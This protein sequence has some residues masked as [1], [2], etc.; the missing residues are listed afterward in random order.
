MNSHDDPDRVGVSVA[1][2]SVRGSAFEYAFE[3]FSVTLLELELKGR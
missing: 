1:K 2:A 3:P